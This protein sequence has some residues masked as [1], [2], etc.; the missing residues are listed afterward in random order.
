MIHRRSKIVPFPRPIRSPRLAPRS[1]FE[2]SQL[3]LAPTCG[4]KFW[5]F[6]DFRGSNLRPSFAAFLSQPLAHSIL[7]GALQLLTGTLQVADL[8]FAQCSCGSLQALQV[9]TPRGGGVPVSNR[10][11]FPRNSVMNQIF[12]PS[13]ATPPLYRTEPGR[14]SVYPR[15]TRRSRFYKSY[16]LPP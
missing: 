11:P 10:P 2:A 9:Q 4:K 1:E 15:D 16:L 3:G 13:G 7:T 12:Q 6:T 5:F 14:C 8:H